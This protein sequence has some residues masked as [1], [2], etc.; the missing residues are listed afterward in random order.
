MNFENVSK[1][2]SNFLFVILF[3]AIIIFVYILYLFSY[4]FTQIDIA[5]LFPLLNGKSYNLIII[6]LACYGYVCSW[7]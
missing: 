4:V 3:P 2:E 1:I 7:N 6:M 5:K